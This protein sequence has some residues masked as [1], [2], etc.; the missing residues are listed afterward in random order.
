MPHL[1]ASTDA[2]SVPLCVPEIRGNE[3]KYVKE[4]LDTSFVSSVGAYVDRFEECV[5]NHVGVRCAVATVNGTA[6]LHTALLVV[7]VQPDDEVLVSTLTF[8][9]PINAIR[10]L[11]AHPL[12][13][14]SESRY[15]QMDVRRVVEFLE[16]GCRWHDGHLYNKATGR[17]VKALLPVAILGHP[18]DM[19]PLVTAA[20]K[21]NLA[22]VEDATEGFGATYRGRPV[23]TLGDIGCLSFN[24][25]KLITTGGGGMLVT[26]D[27]VLASRARYLT[28]QAKDDI[29]EYVHSEVGYNYRLTNIQAAM[30]V[31]QMELID[32]FI[33][34]KRRIAES[35]NLAFE[36]VE[37]ITPIREA[38]W[39]TSAYWLYTVRVDSSKFGMSS[40]ELMHR[41]SGI[42]VQTRPLWQPGH[43][44]AAHRGACSLGGDVAETLFREGLSLPCSVGL[45]DS[46]QQRVVAAIT[47][48][49]R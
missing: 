31:A 4:C 38:E 2:E 35:Y 26:D 20:R 25:N 8:V 45:D 39:A 29:V 28:T 48:S 6:A 42:H 17:R 34:R 9:A 46:T 27:D 36:A 37:G 1:G 24:G 16:N 30:G 14:D 11:G 40:R 44:S 21:Y 18:V 3:W 13:V 15:W 32:E 47:D 5:A 33:C 22:V 19:D 23:A 10:Y 49:A 7:G 43:I 12:F 41:L